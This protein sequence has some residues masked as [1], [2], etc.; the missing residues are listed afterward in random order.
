MTTSITEPNCTTS[1]SPNGNDY[2]KYGRKAFSHPVYDVILESHD[3][4]ARNAFIYIRLILS[5][6]LIAV[7]AIVIRYLLMRSNRDFRYNTY[8]ASPRR[9]S[10]RR[11][12]VSLMPGVVT[13]HVYLHLRWQ[14][15]FT[16]IFSF[17]D[18]IPL[19]MSS[20]VVS[21]H[22]AHIEPIETQ[23]VLEETEL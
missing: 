16:Q 6:Y 18:T 1:P 11:N 3:E 22:E 7:I 4:S 2:I 12:S 15:T 8:N 19:T 23:R 21:P 10:R 9:L 17:Q 20:E 14:F 13:F 5:V